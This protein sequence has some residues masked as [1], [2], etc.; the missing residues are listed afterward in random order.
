MADDKLPGTAKTASQP[1]VATPAAT[2]R[3]LPAGAL[4]VFVADASSKT[5]S[6]VR[7]VFDPSTER[8][9]ANLTIQ[10]QNP[11]LW[12]AAPAADARSGS[13]WARTGPTCTSAT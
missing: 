1:V 7:Y 12:A 9:S 6:V 4:F 11:T 8:L 10:V 3:G 13:H 2:I 5:I